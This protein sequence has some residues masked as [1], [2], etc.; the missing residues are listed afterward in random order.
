MHAAENVAYAFHG[1]EAR[2]VRPKN[3]ERFGELKYS[4]KPPLAGL[5]EAPP[6][7]PVELG[8]KVRPQRTERCRFLAQHAAAGDAHRWS[9]EGYPIRE[10][11]VEDDSQ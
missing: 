10:K 11:L 1:L 5:A 9:V 6:Q 2:L 7:E 4:G 3:Q 8:W